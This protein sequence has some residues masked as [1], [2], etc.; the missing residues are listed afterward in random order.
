MEIQC[1]LSISET[2][3]TFSGDV[4]GPDKLW[5]IGDDFIANT[6]KQYFRD[7]ADNAHYCKGNF[8]ITSFFRT[9]YLTVTTTTLVSSGEYTMQ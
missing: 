1:S 2:N 4:K 5:I 6:F 7:S 3:L 8:E 9:T